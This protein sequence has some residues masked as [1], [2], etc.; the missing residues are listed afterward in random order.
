VLFQVVLPSHPRSPKRA[1]DKEGG[2]LS[3]KSDNQQQKKK[4]K[5]FNL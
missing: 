4:E 1:G 3:D 5:H 2:T